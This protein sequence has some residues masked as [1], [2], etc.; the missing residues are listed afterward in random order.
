MRPEAKQGAATKKPGNKNAASKRPRPEKRAAESG[1]LT[2]AGV[3]ISHPD[4][5]IYPDLGVSK[6]ELA[7]YFEDVARW[8]VPQVA[9]RPLTLV[10][11]PAGLAA[12]CIYLKHA[13]AWGPSALRRIRIQEKTKIGEYL[14]ADSIEAVIALAQMG[15]VEIHTWNATIED[16][17]R[18]NRIVWDLYPGPGVA[19][20]SRATSVRQSS[21][22]IHSFTRRDLPSLGVSARF[23]STTSATIAQIRR[24]VPSRHAHEREPPSPYRSTGVN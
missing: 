20:H 21:E 6:I 1:V 18:P 11:C 8:I 22:P 24:S 15:I 13:K 7:R 14:V 9:G 23:S 2:V 5:L 19:S 4:R 10:H 17:E 3:S 12:P 16:I